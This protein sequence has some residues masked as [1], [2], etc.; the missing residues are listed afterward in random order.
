MDAWMQKY[1]MMCWRG[2]LFVLFSLMASCETHAALLD[3]AT[4]D[5]SRQNIP[6]E[7]SSPF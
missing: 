6:L 7:F 1:R 2:T 5:R 4:F 3:M